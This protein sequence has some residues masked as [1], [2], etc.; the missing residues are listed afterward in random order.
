MKLLEL[1][2]AFA[3][4]DAGEPVLTR[5]LADPRYEQPNSGSYW[6]VAGP[7]GPVLRSRSLWEY[8]LD[9]PRRPARPAVR[10]LRDHRPGR[11]HLDVRERDVRLGQ[12][13]TPRQFRLTVALDHAELQAMGTSFRDDALLALSLIAL[14]L[15]LGAWLQLSLG[16]SPLRRLQAQLADQQG[17]AT[18]LAGAFPAEVAPL[19]T[20]LNTLIDRQEDAAP[21]P[22]A[23]R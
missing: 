5:P 12:A 2:G 16:L 15:L 8:A 21:R 10:R 19:A 11:R 7:S 9:A 4:D 14:V 1:A 17:R 13:G 3:L 22:R 6:Q 23:R 20:S 18:R